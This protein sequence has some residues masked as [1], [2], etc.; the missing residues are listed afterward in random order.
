MTIETPVPPPSQLPADEEAL[1]REARRLRRRRWATGVLTSML[2]AGAAVIAVL[3]ASSNGQAPSPTGP[4]TAGL[5]PT[6]RAAAL[7]LSG[8]LAV[9]PDGALYVADVARDRVLVRLRDGRFRVV[10]GDGRVGF[11]GDGG[12]AVRAELSAVSDLVFA[13]DGSLY[14]ADGGRVRAVSRDGVIRTIAGDGRAPRMITQTVVT[15]CGRLGD[16]ITGK[17][18]VPQLIADGTPAL[19]A[20]LGSPPY[21]SIRSGSPLSIA[22]SPSGQLYISTGSQ[23]LRLIAGGKLDPVPIVIKT[24]PLMRLPLYDLGFGPI[25]VDAHGDIDVAGFNGWAIW[26]L[27]PNGVAHEVGYARLSGG[28]YSVLQPGPDGAIYSES[29]SAIL[30]LEAH[31]LVPTFT[32]NQRLRD[33]YFPLTYFTFSRTGTIY[34]DDLAGGNGFEAHQQLLSANDGHLRLLWQEKNAAPR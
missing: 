4:G 7:G 19:S 25:A 14:I 18:Q 33:Q 21:G 15:C 30:R 5:L 34:A 29:G 10:A 9:A 11:A 26:Q 28:G 17:G 12:P 24:G 1:F 3:I 8:P 6:G 23:I 2:L 27:A 31:K 22:L 20:A 32:F 13:P 16:T